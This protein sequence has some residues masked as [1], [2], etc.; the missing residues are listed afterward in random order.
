MADSRCVFTVTLG[1]L[2]EVP[3]SPYAYW[4][5]PSL[6]DVFQRYPPLDR[7]VAGMPEKPKIAD[8]KVGL[9]TSDDLRFT[10]Y[11]WEVPVEASA[12]NREETLAGKRWVPF[13]KGGKPFYHDITVVVNWGNDGEEIKEFDRAVIRNESFYFRPGLAWVN[14]MSWTG[15]SGFE[16]L[17][18]YHLPGSTIL[19]C[20]YHGVF[21]DSSSQVSALLSWSTAHL[22][23]VLAALLDPNAQNV[24]VGLLARLSV[25]PRVMGHERLAPLAREAYDLLREWATGDETTTVFIAPW[26]LQVWRGF[27]PAQ[28]PVTGHPLARDFAWSDWPSTREVR[29]EGEGRWTGAWSLQDLAGECLRREGLL[30]RRLEEIRRA[31]DEEVYRLY[32]IGD[33]ERR[34]IEEELAQAGGAEEDE[35]AEAAEA[36]EGEEPEEVAALTVKEHVCR[37][38]H[39]F[40]HQAVAR[41]A[42]G[43][44]PLSDLYLADGGREPGLRARVGDLMAAEF[45]GFDPDALEEEIAGTLGKPLEG[46][47]AEDFFPYHLGL[48][49]LRPIIWQFSSAGFAPRRGR[50]AAPVFSCFIYWPRLNSDTLYKVQQ[51]YLKPL[52]AAAGREVERLERELEAARQAPSRLR[53]QKEQEY[54]QALDR[55]EE[56]LA[57]DRALDAM[58]SPAGT[59]PSVESRS[60]WV[61]NVVREI[62]AGGY[63]P[64]LDYGVRVN[65]EP[66]KQAGLLHRDAMRVK[67]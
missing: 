67:G 53:R 39:Y 9:Q 43:I 37:I 58:L 62:S 1:E 11:W 7:D 22:T 33:A 45:N 34:I 59:N 40:A 4:S 5:P 17:T 6:R 16:H 25:N 56:L 21:L 32:G 54:Q 49:R 64:C 50:R 47:L 46:W 35:A 3:G 66:L 14:K 60:E 31:I 15:A 42:D 52:L 24:G 2:A 29:G 10:R 12:A 26:I 41:D 19:A 48:Y 18:S 61:R 38:L 57:F 28:K 20:G 27:D 51:L 13:A 36:S 8:V 65:I 63:R 30:R 55:R 23:A 44:V